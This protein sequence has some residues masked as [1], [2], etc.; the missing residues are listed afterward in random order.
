MINPRTGQQ[1][2]PN[3]QQQFDN[4]Q[5]QNQL[6]QYAPVHIGSAWSGTAAAPAGGIGS[7]SGAPVGYDGSGKAIYRP[8]GYAAMTIAQP[9]QTQW[10]ALGN[11]TTALSSSS[12]RTPIM[13]GSGS[14]I[15]WGPP[16]QA[17]AAP[18]AQPQY[19]S[20]SIGSST[21]FLSNLQQQLG[22]MFGQTPGLGFVQQAQ[23]A[24]QQAPATQSMLRVP[25]TIAPYLNS[26][27]R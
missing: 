13:N 2:Q 19:G 10:N 18:P 26:R 17:P 4:Y 23:P 21:P 11:P 24:Q 9:P 8:P 6:G 7:S 14:V 15:G 5:R 16:A 20:S 3:A 12:P 25:P 22:Q 27:A 1:I